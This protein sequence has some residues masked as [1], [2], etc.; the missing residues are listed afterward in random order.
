[1]EEYLQSARE[2]QLTKRVS[3]PHPIGLSPSLP[4]PTHMQ[5]NHAQ[6][7]KGEDHVFQTD[8]ELCQVA[9]EKEK[10]E[11]I[12]TKTKI[13]RYRRLIYQPCTIPLRRDCTNLLPPLDAGREG[14][15][16]AEDK[17]SNH[18]VSCCCYCCCLAADVIYCIA[19][20]KGLC[21]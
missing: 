6:S 16:A 15:L 8:D 10:V 2:S 11:E 12:S 17:I 14:D 4:D 3:M 20:K 19:D 5:E 21:N 7:K 18:M 9:N 1:M 13:E